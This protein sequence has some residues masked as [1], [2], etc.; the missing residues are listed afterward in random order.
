MAGKG[1]SV[2]F[3]GN[4]EQVE[5][6]LEDLSRDPATELPGGWAVGEKC[7]YLGDSQSWDDG[8]K[9]THGEL[10]TVMGPATFSKAGKGLSVM[11]PGNK[12]QVEVWLKDIS[13]ATELPGGW[14]VGE[15]CH[16]LGDSKSW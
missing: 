4:K 6:W 11:F 15:K 2:M 13:P 5:V 10:G 7:H 1:L 12:E 16:Y 9:L 3:P 14:A 8:D